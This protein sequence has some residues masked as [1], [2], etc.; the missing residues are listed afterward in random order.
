MVLLGGSRGHCFPACAPDQHQGSASVVPPCV[1][2]P[3][4]HPNR[5]CFADFLVPNSTVKPSLP[6]VSGHPLLP[7]RQTQGGST[8]RASVQRAA[9]T[10]C[11][12]NR[13]CASKQKRTQALPRGLRQRYFCPALTTLFTGFSL[14]GSLLSGPHF[15]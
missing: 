3:A 10:L 6:A 12:I 9:D 1:P 13:P 11:R 8:P 5:V 2:Q 14:C 15:D 4:C 7:Q